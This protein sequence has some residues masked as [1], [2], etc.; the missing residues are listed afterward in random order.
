MKKALHI[1]S[2]TNVIILEEVGVDHLKVFL[3]GA[4]KTVAKADVQYEDTPKISTLT[5]LNRFI[6]S[7]IIHEPVTDMIYSYQSNHLIP[8]HHQYKPLIKMI[9]SP[10]NR[11]LIADEVG[12]GKTIE[13]GMILK[14]V[15]KRDDV[16]IVLI[17]VPSSLTLKWKEEMFIRF[18]E[19][20][21]ILRTYEFIL[22]LDEYKRYSDS[23]VFIKRII[24]SYH[25]LRNEAI[26]KRLFDNPLHIDFLIMDESH[27]FRNRDTSTFL[28]AALVT[29]LAQH[30]VFLSATPVQNDISDLYNQLTLLDDERFMDFEHFKHS[31]EPNSIIHKVVAAIKNGQKINEVKNLAIS[32]GYDK[33]QMETHQKA[34]FDQLMSYSELSQEDRVDFVKLFTEADNLSGIISRTKKKDVGRIIPREATSHAILGTEAERNYYLAV[35]EFVKLAYA[36]LKPEAPQ[37]FISIMP[38]RMASSCMI[39]SVKSFTKMKATGK[40]LFTD[41][42]DYD[43]EIG[44]VEVSKELFAMLDRVV[45]LGNKI[46]EHDSK[47]ISFL[48]ILNELKSQKIKKL[49]VFSFFKGTLSYLYDRLFEQG[50]KIGKIDGDITSEERYSVINQFRDGKFDIL[51]S[52]E[53]GSEGLDMQFCNVIVNYDLPWN[54]M[55]VEQRIG[56]IDRI[57]QKADKLLIFN[58][59]IK[60]TIEDRILTRLYEKLDIFE[61]SIGELEPILGDIQNTFNIAEM[62]NLSDTEIE[63]IVDL[64]AQALLRQ[65]KE[66]QEQNFTLDM[67]L[68]NSYN[69]D[70][71][72]ESYVSGNKQSFIQTSL[73]DVVTSFLKNNNVHFQKL[74]NSRYHL[75]KDDTQKL[76]EIVKPQL[77][78]SKDKSS[79]PSAKRALFD[80]KRV[81][82]YTFTFDQ[83]QKQTFDVDYLSLTHPLVKL[84]SSYTKGKKYASVSSSLVK[85][86][87]ALVYRQE[88]NAIKLKTSLRTVIFSSDFEVIQELD[89]YSFA[90]S[91]KETNSDIN[92]N[93][94]IEVQ[95]TL[96]AKLMA[97]TQEQLAKIEQDVA[98]VTERKVAALKAYYA[99]QRQRALKQLEKVDQLEVVRM[100]RA[101]VDNIDQLEREK[102][103]MLQKQ[104]KVS[105][106]NELLAVL[107]LT[108]A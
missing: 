103:S 39:A 37:G 49:I 82:T 16:N 38:E 7:S 64:K 99:K 11:I 50:F 13:A 34:L 94:L 8:E 56:R 70:E 89:Y 61:S 83:P 5:E 66:I 71:D 60:G 30:I 3:N 6:I 100:K 29:S 57:G 73:E 9:Q 54:P 63:R 35:V 102:I 88:V 25:T 2:N 93:H 75:G 51:L 17:V 15:D 21:D 68:E 47:Y 40:M 86:G 52:S 55:R 48:E 42:D 104:E 106:S 81:K 12:L 78:H 87:Y 41:V 91:V 101:Q 108:H 14:E 36:H 65:K 45:S 32:L 24:V 23:K 85:K 107:E 33:L 105:G 31:V 80:L 43:E 62:I 98:L 95:K 90:V 4:E 59:C 77:M 72:Y 67:M 20:F 74:E 28:S 26:T 10:N 44:D 76:F 22:F 18:D 84:M 92:I 96:E 1:P 19:T 69:Y 53:V 58:L 46:G 79:Y 97:F 27:T